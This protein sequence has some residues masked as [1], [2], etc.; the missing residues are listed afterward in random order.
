MET[1]PIAEVVTRS[2]QWFGDAQFKKVGGACSHKFYNVAGHQRRLETK[3]FIMYD[4]FVRA[5]G[6]FSECLWSEL[7]DTA[8]MD[9]FSVERRAHKHQLG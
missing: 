4:P 8:S 1:A 6:A 2:P 7:K 3:P 5:I 9:F